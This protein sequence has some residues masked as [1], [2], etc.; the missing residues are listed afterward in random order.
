MLSLTLLVSGLLGVPVGE[1][2]GG[3]LGLDP[4]TGWTL[5]ALAPQRRGNPTCAIAH[6]DLVWH[7]HVRSSRVS[8]CGKGQVL[9]GLTWAGWMALSQT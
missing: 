4:A 2:K 9:T 5:T 8:P 7:L 6:S 3:A 1:L